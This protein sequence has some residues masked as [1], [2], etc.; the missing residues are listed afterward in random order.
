MVDQFE[1]KDWIFVL[2]LT[3]IFCIGVGYYV[4]VDNA[5][6]RELGH[7][8]KTDEQYPYIE[9][10]YEFKYKFRENCHSTI[11]VDKWGYKNYGFVC[12]DQRYENWSLN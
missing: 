2:V 11:T 9:C 8:W 4:Y 1:G 3:L 10:D 7:N 6:C 12:E 5:V